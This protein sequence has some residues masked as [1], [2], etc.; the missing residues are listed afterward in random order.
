MKKRNLLALLVATLL[1]AACGG[2]PSSAPANDPYRFAP[3]EA[4]PHPP[5]GGS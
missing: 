4:D 5:I 1:A 3:G 2:M